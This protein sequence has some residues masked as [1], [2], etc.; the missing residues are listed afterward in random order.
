MRAADAGNDSRAQ[1]AGGEMKRRA[2]AFPRPGDSSPPPNGDTG[3][4][5]APPPSG[6]DA[7][8]AV[9]AVIVRFGNLMYRVGRSLRLPDADIDEAIQD[10]R[11]RLW[12][13]L[14][15]GEGVDIQ[16]LPATYVYRTTMSAMLDLLRRRRSRRESA[17]ESLEA[18][19]VPIASQVVSPDAGL[20]T[21]DLTRQV[22]AAIEEITES[23]RGV[24]RMYL[25]GY[26]REEIA[27]LLGWSEPKT[28]NL[29]YR[30]MD[31]LRARLRARGIGTEAER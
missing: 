14:A 8:A 28:R 29:L 25:A 30:G 9:D 12:R 1:R 21:E 4:P 15:S 23:R 27:Q 7:S 31:D 26:A 11:I 22:A 19:V 13:T 3:R 17:V 18:Q 16:R 20:Y 24:V 6:D 2:L 10:V 5:D